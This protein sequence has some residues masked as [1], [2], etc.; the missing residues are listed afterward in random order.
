M[1]MLRRSQS[2][3]YST[4]IL[5]IVQIN[6]NLL[7]VQLKY[8]T[9]NTLYRVCKIIEYYV[10]VFCCSINLRVET[11]RKIMKGTEGMMLLNVPQS[12][13]VYRTKYKLNAA[14]N[15]YCVHVHIAD[16]HLSIQI[17]FPRWDVNVII[18]TTNKL[19]SG[20]HILCMLGNVTITSI[21][22]PSVLTL[23]MCRTYRSHHL[24]KNIIN[25]ATVNFLST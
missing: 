2:I 22:V 24:N 13:K 14:R 20:H 6:E 23:N 9:C 8:I 25:A 10:H 4:Y 21:N 5:H 3:L 1:W 17:Q 12:R 7:F 19:L 11:F 18:L 15:L 16:V